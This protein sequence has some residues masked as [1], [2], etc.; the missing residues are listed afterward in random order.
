M[1]KIEYISGGCEL[2]DL[3]RPLWERLNEHHRVNSKY[4]SERY[5]NLTFDTR[6]KKF[7][8]DTDIKVNIDLVHD[9]EKNLYVGYCISTIRRDEIGEIDSLYVDTCCRKSGIGDTLMQRAIEW[10]NTNNVK[11]KMIA[12]AEGNESVLDFYKRHNFYPRRIVLEEIINKI[13]D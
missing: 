5:D 10:L 6:K 4:F 12:V 1:S 7:I 9:M 2:L 11:Q 13:E 3:V 8:D